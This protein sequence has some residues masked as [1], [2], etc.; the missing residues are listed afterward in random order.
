MGETGCDIWGKGGCVG[1]FKTNRCEDRAVV[2]VPLERVDG[3]V[4]RLPL[5]DEPPVR[6][7]VEDLEGGGDP[8]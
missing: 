2:G 8:G 3:T 7:Q 5:L 1:G 6:A 4:V